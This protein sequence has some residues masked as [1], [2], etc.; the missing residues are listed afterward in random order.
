ML[1]AALVSGALMAA[2]TL[3]P[4]EA[5]P[6]PEGARARPVSFAELAGWDAD[7]HRAAFAAFART[8]TLV[9]EK[10]EP[11][12]SG[13]AAPDALQQACRA[14]LALKTPDASAARGFFERHFTPFRIEPEAGAGFL[15]GYFEPEIA[16]SLAPAPGFPVPLLAPPASLENLPARAAIEDGALG[17]A[18]KPVVYLTDAVDAFMVHVQGSTRIRLP[19]GRAIRVGY[20]GRNGHPYSSVGRMAVDAGHLTREEATADRLYAWLKA[21]PRIARDLMRANASYIFFRIVEGLDP[22]LGP[23]GGASVQLTLGRSLAVDRNVWSYGLPVWIEADLGDVDGTGQPA[24]R[25]TVAQDTGSAIVGPARADL[26]TGSGAAAGIV[27]GRI[28]HPLGFTVLWPRDPGPRDP[29]K[30]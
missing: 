15:T 30:P 7:D 3:G 5:Q 18:A 14:A 20:A 25:L 28:R 6:A 16:G 26:F 17:D 24:R 8:C 21:N 9:T 4:A 2:A 11:L 22:A 13:R 1:R 10:A 19:D 12:R 23:V 27:A 29:A